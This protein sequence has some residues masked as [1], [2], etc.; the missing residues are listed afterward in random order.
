M[1][2]WKTHSASLQINMIR[3]MEIEFELK[4]VDN[5]QRIRIKSQIISPSRLCS[6]SLL[7]CCLWNKAEQRAKAK[8]HRV[9]LLNVNEGGTHDWTC[10]C[11]YLL[12]RRL[13][14]LHVR[15]SVFNGSALLSMERKEWFGRG[16]WGE[17]WPCTSVSVQRGGRTNRRLRSRVL[18]FPRVLLPPRTFRRNAMR[19]GESNRTHPTSH[20]PKPH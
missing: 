7:H 11:F 19:G 13:Q 14:M 9:S 17:N 6:S 15:Q 18:T 16:R 10:T 20:P 12:K 1:I 2:L 4:H 3:F 8:S 5:K